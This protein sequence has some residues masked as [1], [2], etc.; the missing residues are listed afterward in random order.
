MP[1]GCTILCSVQ[2]P[3]YVSIIAP[4][5]ISKALKYKDISIA[6]RLAHQHNSQTKNGILK[7]Q[8]H[9]KLSILTGL[10]QLVLNINETH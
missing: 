1:I 6:S 3:F 5:S 4:I 2:L 8:K 7:C 9:I 10:D